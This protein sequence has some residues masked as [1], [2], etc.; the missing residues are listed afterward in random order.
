MNDKWHTSEPPKDERIFGQY[1]EHIFGPHQNVD[2]WNAPHVYWWEESEQGWVCNED[3]MIRYLP[4]ER[5]REPP[6]ETELML[7]QLST[8][9]DIMTDLA[10]TLPQIIE[11]ITSSTFDKIDQ[12]S[13]S[14]LCENICNKEVRIKNIMKVSKFT[15]LYDTLYDALIVKRGKMLEDMYENSPTVT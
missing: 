1:H 13:Y 14:T 5:W 9:L 15:K 2:G 3:N 7:E 6:C 4:P 8:T 11:K 12:S 10:E